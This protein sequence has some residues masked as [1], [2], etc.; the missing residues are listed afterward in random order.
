M[1]KITALTADRQQVM[2]VVTD[3]NAL[4][5]VEAMRKRGYLNITVN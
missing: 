4:K 2:S 3:E 5:E 1:K